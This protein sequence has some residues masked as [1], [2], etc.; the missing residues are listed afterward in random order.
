MYDICM[1]TINISLPKKLHEKATELV[2]KGYYASFSDLT[3]TAV[4]R[5]IGQGELDLISEQT[6]KNYKKGKAVVLKSQ[7]DIDEFFDKL[8]NG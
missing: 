5:L 6:Q 1:N 7:A 2:K 3:R 8:D 4:R